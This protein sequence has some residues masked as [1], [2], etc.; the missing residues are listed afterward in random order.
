[1]Q[2]KAQ[3][4]AAKVE[5]CQPQSL[6]IPEEQKEKEEEAQRETVRRL[7]EAITTRKQ[8]KS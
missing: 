3:R 6:T 8:L 4:I 2:E 1:M 5:Q 7:Q